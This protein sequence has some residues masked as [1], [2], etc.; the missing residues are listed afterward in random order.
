M[1]SVT[2]KFRGFHPAPTTNTLVA[3]VLNTDFD[4]AGSFLCSSDL[5]N[6]I[7]TNTLW[8]LPWQFRRHIPTDCPHREKNGW[9]GDA[10]L[11]SEIGLTHFRSARPLTPAA[12]GVS[13]GP[14]WPTEDFME[15]SQRCLGRKRRPSLGIGHT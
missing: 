11:A 14:I 3:R 5:L 9:T 12:S 4:L 7:E 6:R 1:V 15:S 2:R 13:P 8:S 10:Q